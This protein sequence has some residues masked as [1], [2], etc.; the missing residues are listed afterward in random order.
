MRLVS[1]CSCKHIQGLVQPHSSKSKLIVEKR[2]RIAE[3]AAH[4]HLI[5]S[6]DTLI[7]CSLSTCMGP[8]GTQQSCLDLK[9]ITDHCFPGFTPNYRHTLSSKGHRRENKSIF[10]WCQRPQNLLS[11]KQCSAPSSGSTVPLEIP[12]IL[13]LHQPYTTLPILKLPGHPQC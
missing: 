7:Q 9:D 8:P 1:C 13:C 10:S 2:Q 12:V 3:K 4:R 6:S 5:L 11:P